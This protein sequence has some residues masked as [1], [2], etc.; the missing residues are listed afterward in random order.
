MAKNVLWIPINF[1]VQTKISRGIQATTAV[2]IRLFLMI[3]YFVS[4]FVYG[5]YQP[6]WE[7]GKLQNLIL[8]HSYHTIITWVKRKISRGSMLARKSI[9]RRPTTKDNDTSS[10]LPNGGRVIN[11]REHPPVIGQHSAIIMLALCLVRRPSSLLMS[12]IVKIF[13]PF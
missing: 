11:L 6:V 13:A 3:Y 8:Q 7:S 5:V 12:R 4:V 1:H 10:V 9:L 2:H